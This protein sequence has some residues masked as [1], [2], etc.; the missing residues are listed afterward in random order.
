[1]AS[2]DDGFCNAMQKTPLSC[3]SQCGRCGW[4]GGCLCDGLSSVPVG[5]FSGGGVVDLSS[6]SCCGIQT[7]C[8][9][10]IF[11]KNREIHSD[12]CESDYAHSTIAKLGNAVLAASH[13]VQSLSASHTVQSLG[14]R[15]SSA[16]S[17]CHFGS[18]ALK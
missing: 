17:A 2:R 5:C 18:S 1:M 14:A 3:S 7:L 13:S 15:H 4:F 16:H 9:A 10:S 12:L 8:N 11:H 6:W